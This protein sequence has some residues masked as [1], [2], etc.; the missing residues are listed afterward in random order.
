MD[1]KR[2]AKFCCLMAVILAP[3]TWAIARF[4]RDSSPVH[5]GMSAQVAWNRIHILTPASST[6]S[7][8][9][10]YA[11]RIEREARWGIRPARIVLKRRT[12]YSLGTNGIVSGVHTAWT[13]ALPPPA[14]KSMT[15]RS[16]QLASQY[17][18]PAITRLLR[19]KGLAMQPGSSVFWNKREGTLVVRASDKDH[20]KIAK[21]LKTAS[22]E[23]APPQEQ[24]PHVT[25][26][27]AGLSKPRLC[28]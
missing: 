16:Y 13:L 23:L 19:Q 6:N 28:S 7:T 10:S 27:D 20:R 17:S 3:M 11:D 25:A 24:L 1:M 22:Q 2:R 5:V 21:L 18:F 4:P 9:T 26:T 14:A 15:V 8:W 12:I